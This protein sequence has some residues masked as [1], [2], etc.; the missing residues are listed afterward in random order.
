MNLSPRATGGRLPG[1]GGGGER[2]WRL[3]RRYIKVINAWGDPGGGGTERGFRIPGP[4]KPQFQEPLPSFP[5]LTHTPT[6]P[7][8]LPLPGRRKRMVGRFPIP[9]WPGNSRDRSSGL[10]RDARVGEPG[11]SGAESRETGLPGPG[12]GWGGTP[13]TPACP[14]VTD[15]CPPPLPPYRPPT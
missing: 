15:P 11:T 7:P 6:P 14:G 3:G 10:P 12:R 2:V 13:P 9:A 1:R 5:E 8:G 4:P